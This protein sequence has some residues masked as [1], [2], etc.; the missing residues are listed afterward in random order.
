M[1]STPHTSARKGKRVIVTLKNG[2]KILDKFVERTGKGIVLEKNGF[3]RG[4]DLRAMTIYRGQDMS[5]FD[6]EE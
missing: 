1:G 4:R 6:D 3:I 2:K 5:Q